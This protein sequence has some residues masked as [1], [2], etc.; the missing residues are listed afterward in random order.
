MFD[1]NR[2]SDA[3]AEFKLEDTAARMERTVDMG[4][5]LRSCRPGELAYFARIAGL[6]SQSTHA[7]AR[8][9]GKAFDVLLDAEEARREF[10]RARTLA[11]FDAIAA[12]ERPAPT[13]AN[14]DSLPSWS[15]VSP[16]APD[17]RTN[18]ET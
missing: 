15:E 18:A 14:L 2:C 10:D 8:A 13:E 6:W 4:A 1:D 11:M 3:R 16:A 12:E 17:N 5:V 7:G 9:V